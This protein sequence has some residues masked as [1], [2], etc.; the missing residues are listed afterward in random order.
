MYIYTP[1]DGR[2]PVAVLVRGRPAGGFGV[3][4]VMDVRGSWSRM[5]NL[6]KEFWEGV[7]CFLDDARGLAR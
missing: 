1:S 2:V 3:E 6:Y 4:V 5:L 7:F